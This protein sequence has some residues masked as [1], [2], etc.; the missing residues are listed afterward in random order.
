MMDKNGILDQMRSLHAGLR[1]DLKEKYN[2]HVSFGDLLV[3][4]WER[5]KAYGFGEGASCYD[6]VLVL[7]DVKIGRNT[8]IGPNVIL[9]GS[10]GL[11]IG[12]FCSI[13]AGVQIYTHHSVKWA[14]SMG[15]DEPERAPTVIGSGVFIGPQAV[16]AMGVAI[17]DRAVIGAMSYV[18]RDVPADARAF[19][20]P[21]RIQP[22]AD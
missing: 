16:I 5:A 1:N 18:D 9:D 13:N 21:A 8:W 7:G 10:A 19:G 15:E 14:T 11:E 6:N 3:D 12:D 4:R 22:S 20:T 17:G 2:R